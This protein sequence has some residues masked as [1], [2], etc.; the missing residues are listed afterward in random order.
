MPGTGGRAA[1]RRRG[2][3]LVPGGHLAEQ[4]HLVPGGD[5][6]VAARA[7]HRLAVRRRALDPERDERLAEQVAQHAVPRRGHGADLHD[8]VVD[9]QAVALGAEARLDDGRC[10]DRRDVE[11]QDARVGVHRP[12]H[13]GVADLRDHRELGAQAPDQQRGLQRAQVGG[14]QAHHGARLAEP[15]GVQG[16]AGAVHVLHDGRAQG[17][18]GLHGAGPRAV[19]DRDHL[20]VQGHQVLDHAQPEPLEAVH[21]HVPGPGL[22]VGGHGGMIPRHVGQR[23]GTRRGGP[24][25]AQPPQSPRA[26]CSAPS[27]ASTRWPRSSSGQPRPTQVRTAASTK[28]GQA[29]SA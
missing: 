29:S 13:R 12:G 15:R 26:P 14:G 4:A 16:R 21:D 9:A 20:D 10:R 22:V 11:H 1:R 25:R 18:G 24:A 2:R 27:V 23:E 17:R 3:H 7:H 19:V 28:P 6:E 8:L 5:L